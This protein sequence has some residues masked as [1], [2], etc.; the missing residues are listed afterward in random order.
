MIL[1]ETNVIIEALKKNPLVIQTIEK[2]G[3]ERRVCLRQGSLIFITSDLAPA[4]ISTWS[5]EI[6]DIMKESRIFPI[7]KRHCRGEL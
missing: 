4:T 1:C 6:G 7:F 2:I 5:E 3:L